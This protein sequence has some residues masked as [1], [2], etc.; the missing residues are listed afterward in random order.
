MT[1]LK[2]HFV[3]KMV[4]SSELPNYQR[5]YRE[6]ASLYTTRWLG[7]Q[8]CCSALWGMTWNP[9]TNLA[10]HVFQAW[11]TEPFWLSLFLINVLTSALSS[12][13]VPL[14][15]IFPGEEK[16]ARAIW[17]ALRWNC[18]HAELSVLADFYSPLCNVKNE[19]EFWLLILTTI[20][21]LGDIN[22]FHFNPG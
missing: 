19:S 3:C 2:S 20:I 12:F 21:T 1:A 5:P 18:C 22:G 8:R 14:A 7:I 9:D 11:T 10:L 15:M 17:A 4:G 6:N 13:W 16:P